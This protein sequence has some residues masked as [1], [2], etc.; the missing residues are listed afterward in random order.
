METIYCQYLF[1]WN[2]W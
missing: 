1:Y 2:Y